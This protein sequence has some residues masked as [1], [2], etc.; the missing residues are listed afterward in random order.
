MTSLR[1]GDFELYAS[2]EL[3]RWFLAFD[4]TNFSLIAMY[5]FHEHIN[6][7]LQAGGGD[8]SDLYDDTDSIALYELA[9]PDSVI[10]IK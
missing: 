4:N 6:R 1:D 3:C 7:Q 5:Q 10:F 2:D 8:L 9:A